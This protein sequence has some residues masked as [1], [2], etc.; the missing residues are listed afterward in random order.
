VKQAI[1]GRQPVLLVVDDVPDNLELLARLFKE[2]G[3]QV[4]LAPSGAMALKAVQ[5]Q[6]PDLILLDINMPEMN[7]FE[8]C[9]HLK[10]QERWRQIPIVFISALGDAKAK[11]EAF[12]AGG[13]DYVTKPFQFTEVAARVRTHLQLHF[14]QENLEQMVAAQVKEIAETQLG[15]IFALAKLAESR[16]DETGDHLERVRTCCRLLAEALLQMTECETVTDESFVR[17]IE[18]ASS[19]HDIGK[20]GI[21]DGI[22]LKPGRLTP[23]EFEKMKEHTLIGA[24]TLESVRER[25]P[26]NDFL[27]TCIEIVRW[28]HER[29]DGAGYPDGLNGG[30]IP[31][32]AR[33]MAV[34]DV[35][36]ALRSRRCYKAPLS[37]EESGRILRE[38]SGSQFDPL[39]IK[40][41]FMVENEIVAAYEAIK[42]NNY[43]SE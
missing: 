20:V 27:V 21:P 7:G 23:A 34:A 6:L 36:D 38:G 28:H 29:W 10:E 33:I 35:Y 2:E 8:V 30:I 19:L 22:L 32:T 13:V 25:Y 31:L 5:A 11:V 12:E 40:A 15:T 1:F 24:R 26:H 3:Y 14:Y 42:E 39:V 4:R 17:T 16:D 43:D 18:Q 37:H 9:R 41:F